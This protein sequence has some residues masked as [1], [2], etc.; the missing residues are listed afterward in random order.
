VNRSRKRFRSLTPYRHPSADQ[1]G[2]RRVN[3]LLSGI[4]AC[5]S[6]SSKRSSPLHISGDVRR[7]QMRQEL[8]AKIAVEICEGS[9]LELFAFV[10]AGI[11]E[12][13]HGL[14]RGDADLSRSYELLSLVE[15]EI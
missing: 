8:D 5:Q 13:L 3:V 11:I 4:T 14:I 1:H 7:Y 15:L 9:R 2:T 6:W 12:K 10:V